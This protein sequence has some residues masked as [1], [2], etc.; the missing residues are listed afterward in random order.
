MRNVVFVAPFPLETTM[1]FARAAAGLAGVRL[2]GI[3]Q[4]PPRGGDASLFADGMTFI[5]ER[6]GWP[7]LGLV[8]HFAEA[9]RLPAE[10]AVALSRAVSARR[11]GARLVIAVPV[12]PCIANFDDGRRERSLSWSK[13]RQLRWTMSK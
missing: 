9:A 7:A 1:R 5:A 6:S 13:C 2:L 12:C 8:P 10:Y 11:A 3:V 4:E